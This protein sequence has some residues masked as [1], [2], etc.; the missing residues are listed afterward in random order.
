MSKYNYKVQTKRLLK[1]AQNSKRN[2]ITRKQSSFHMQT[3]TI[4]LQGF[5]LVVDYYS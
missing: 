2:L 3:M 1:F 4:R 5:K